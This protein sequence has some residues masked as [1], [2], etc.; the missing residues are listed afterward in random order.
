MPHIPDFAFRIYRKN[1]SWFKRTEKGI[2]TPTNEKKDSPNGQWYKS[3]SGKIIHMQ[4]L[5]EN[6]Y[7]VPEDDYHVRI[8]SKEYFEIL[9]RKLNKS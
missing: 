1:M 5:R 4:E 6:S 2:Q 8:G 7:V 3:P 9:E